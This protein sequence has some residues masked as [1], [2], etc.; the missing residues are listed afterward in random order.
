MAEK[1]VHARIP[2]DKHLDWTYLGTYRLQPLTVFFK[3]IS[4]TEHRFM[5]WYQWP[6]T[7][8][9]AGALSVLFCPERACPPPF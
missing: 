8:K 4:K 9:G 5:Y 6:H 3:D 7:D 2:F 1:A